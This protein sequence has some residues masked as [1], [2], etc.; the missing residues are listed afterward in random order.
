MGKVFFFSKLGSVFFFF[1]F[2]GGG[3]GGGILEIVVDMQP[4]LKKTNK[5]FLFSNLYNIISVRCVCG[6]FTI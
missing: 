3:G 4:I 5:L 1:F 2:G 6:F